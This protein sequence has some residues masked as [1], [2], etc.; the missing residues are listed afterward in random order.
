LAPNLICLRLIKCLFCRKQFIF[1]FLRVFLDKIRE[2]V[3][4]F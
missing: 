2:F 1:F 3:Y 4:S